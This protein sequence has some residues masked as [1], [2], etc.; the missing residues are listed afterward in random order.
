M[1][2]GPI[3]RDRAYKVDGWLEGNILLYIDGRRC[4]ELRLQP[5]LPG[6]EYFSGGTKVAINKAAFLRIDN[7]GRKLVNDPGRPE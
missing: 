7:E 2:G 1:T 4:S 5:E 6:Q 3:S